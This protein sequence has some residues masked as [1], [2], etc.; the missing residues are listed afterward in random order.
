MEQHLKV[1]GKL[2]QPID[3]V[4]ASISG[5]TTD[6]GLVRIEATIER[7]QPDIIIIELGANDGL[8]GFPIPLIHANLTR[9]VHISKQNASVLLLGMHMLPNYGRRYS[10]A[11]FNVFQAVADQNDIE[12]VPFFLEGVATVEGM[13]Q[14]DGMHPTQQAQPRLVE[15]VLKKLEPMLPAIVE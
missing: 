12:L 10:D 1:R 5:E 8:R 15:N 2:A 11:F 3:V 13:M 6:G 7:H 9:L 4:N 14:A